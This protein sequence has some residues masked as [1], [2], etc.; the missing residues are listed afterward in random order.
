MRLQPF[1]ILLWLCTILLSACGSPSVE[2][3]SPV[4]SP[5]SA[6]SDVNVAA[7]LAAAAEGNETFA[8]P[9]SRLVIIGIAAPGANPAVA[10]PPPAQPAAAPAHKP[11]PTPA[12]P[13]PAQLGKQPSQLAAANSGGNQT[14]GQTSPPSTITTTL[15]SADQTIKY[16][17][18][19]VQVESVVSFMVKPVNNFFSQNDFGVTRLP[20]TRIPTS[21]SNTFTDETATNVKS[22]LGIISAAIPLFAAAAPSHGDEGN[23]AAPVCLSDDFIVDDDTLKAPGHVPG[24]NFARWVT[25]KDNWVL[26]GAGKCLDVTINANPLAPDLV[27]VAALAA[28]LAG[29]GGDWTKVWPVPACMTAQIQ[30]GPAG[31]PANDG[32][33]ATSQITLIDP[34]YVE[35]MPIPQKGKLAMNPICGADLA[36]TGS[37]PYQS[38]FD[39]MTAIES[40]F[41]SKSSSK[42]KPAS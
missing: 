28:A 33:V 41:P 15:T 40:V 31:A 13:M 36:D 7:I 24:P 29:N 38:T 39:T 20:N 11:T 5:I 10:T 35:L 34:D 25:R 14:G 26:Q 32:R 8:L 12:A 6:A 4:P 42:S 19:T 37:N 21:V 2:Y 16:T 23:A 3:A 9:V 22:A 17:V 27:P 30:V 1:R 18:N